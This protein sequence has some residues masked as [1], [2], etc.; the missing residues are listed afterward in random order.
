MI[1]IA[2]NCGEQNVT[3]N[4]VNGQLQL[5]TTRSINMDECL[6]LWPSH[7]LLNEWN[8]PDYLQLANFLSI[9]QYK[10]IK[11]NKCYQEPNQLKIH[12]A[13]SCFNKSPNF[14]RD[15]DKLLLMNTNAANS[16]KQS[17]CNNF[18]LN[19]PYQS[20]FKNNSTNF[21][22]GLNPF[23]L[24][25]SL[26]CNLLNKNLNSLNNLSNVLISNSSLTNHNISNIVS[27]NI[28]NNNYLS[29][30]QQMTKR[31][32]IEE[33]NNNLLNAINKLNNLNNL[34]SLNSNLNEVQKTSE[35]SSPLD[36]L[37]FRRNLECLV[38]A[39]KLNAKKNQFQIKKPADQQINLNDSDQSSSDLTDEL[40]GDKFSNHPPINLMNLNNNNLSNKNR[41]LKATKEPRSH[42]CK[43]C[44]KLYTRKYGL[45]IHIRTHTGKIKVLMNS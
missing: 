30:N 36:S 10:C 16:I 3:L 44:G 1:E 38:D 18:L 32:K 8:I 7:N 28:L 20:L 22:T 2:N 27:S 19:H 13:L 15:N 45:K 23:S 11:C 25:T 39:N 5:C 41:A 35:H 29:N 6:K 4:R 14:N 26:N 33:N 12:I 21:T 37:D 31:L 43:F 42:T 9:N 40:S 34:N 17:M 24:S